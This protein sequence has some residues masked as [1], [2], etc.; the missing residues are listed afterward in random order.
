MASVSIRQATVADVNVIAPLFDGY[1]EWYRQPANSPK[2]RAFLEARLTSGESTVFLA[3]EGSEAVGM[4][5]LYPLF[6]SLTLGKH[7]LLN[8]LYVSPS[9]R[10]KGI[11]KLLI[12]RC[13]EL[14]KETGA[15]GLTLETEKTNNIGN[16]LYPSAGLTLDTQHNFYFWVN[17]E[18]KRDS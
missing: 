8:D 14:C 12:N 16:A 11:S 18:Y 15:S 7:W 9:R 5:Q 2:A 17:P 1:L 3:Y 10:G 6:S 4:A 13:Y